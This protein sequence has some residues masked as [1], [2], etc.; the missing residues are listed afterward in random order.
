MYDRRSHD[1]IDTGIMKLGLFALL[2]SVELEPAEIL[3]VYYIRQQIE[4]VFDVSKNYADILPLRVANERTLN[5]H[6]FLCFI[7]TVV[8][9][10][11]LQDTMKKRKK[12]SRLNQ[13]GIFMSLRNHKSKVFD[14]MLVPYTAA[15][16]NNELYKMFDIKVP[17][18][19]PWK[20]GDPK[21]EGFPELLLEEPEEEID[22]L[23]VALL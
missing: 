9:Q 4:Q 6:L 21:D 1:E 2:S 8:M 11:L 22:D 16:E 12:K 5:G 10:K 13:F 23:P 7:A 14:H 20:G 15:A 19:I 18:R 17:V 3:P